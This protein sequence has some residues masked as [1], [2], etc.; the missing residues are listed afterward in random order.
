VM[1]ALSPPNSAPDCTPF[2]LEQVNHHIRCSQIPYPSFANTIYITL[3]HHICDSLT[4]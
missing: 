2:K 3:G 1:T 4:P